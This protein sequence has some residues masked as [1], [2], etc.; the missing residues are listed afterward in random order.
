MK[1][2]CGCREV[3]QT[4]IEFKIQERPQVHIDTGPLLPNTNELDWCKLQ[5]KIICDFQK[6]IKQL[7]CGIQPD[8]EIILEQISLIFMNS[9]G[10]NVAKKMYATDSE[11]DYFLKHNNFLS[12]FKTQEEKD[13]VLLNLGIYDKFK[14]M[15]T[16]DELNENLDKKI[17]FVVPWEGKWYY[18]FAS[19]EHYGRWIETK[20]DS[21]IL[22]R[23]MAGD[24]VPITYTIQFDNMGGDPVD[25]ISVNDGFHFEFPS[26]TW[27]NDITR[28]FI[29][30]YTN[31][32]FIG[33]C[34]IPGDKIIPTSGMVFYA[35][36]Y[37]EPKTLSFYPNYGSDNPIVINSYLG[38]TINLNEALTR[39]GYTFNGWNTARDGSGNNYNGG[40]SYI[41]NDN[42]SF[43]AQWSINTY[44]ITFD[45]NYPSD[46]NIPSNIIRTVNYGTLI[47]ENFFP[48]SDYT[49]SDGKIVKRWNVYRDGTGQ[50]YQSIAG[51][52]IPQI[53]NN[54]TFYAQ[55]EYGYKYI[56]VTTIPS[57]PLIWN[58][59]NTR[60]IQLKNLI[61]W[62]EW[63]GQSNQY[64]IV[65]AISGKTEID[66]YIDIT[67]QFNQSILDDFEIVE[68][69]LQNIIVIKQS[70]FSPLDDSDGN[71]NLILK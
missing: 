35:K 30:W 36:W 64:I 6:L 5:T 29:G 18:G 60:Q 68:S 52:I 62:N 40:Y 20:D 32:E 46:P 47:D 16:K 49:T 25:N 53:G 43:Y 9:C 44:T 4:P 23:W 70:G 22:G 55:W 71:G 42:Q 15:L 69:S 58:Y 3:S 26:A 39:Q 54:I 66:E 33:N 65:P 24:Y 51:D 11:E 21:L 61:G 41:I 14:E 13:Q 1:N 2:G 67:D 63:M 56:L 8:I 28:Q 34:Y 27:S 37:R 57:E 19:N 50:N 59:A 10:Y 45:F 38:E 31:R 7:E 12:E 48:Q 17:G